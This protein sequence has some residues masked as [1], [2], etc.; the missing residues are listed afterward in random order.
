MFMFGVTDG[1]G[2]GVGAGGVGDGPTPPKRLSIVVMF[3][4]HCA[5]KAEIMLALAE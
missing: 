5:C 2:P 3:A 4:G 1:V